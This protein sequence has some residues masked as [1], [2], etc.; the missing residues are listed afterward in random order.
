[1][2]FITSYESIAVAGSGSVV[3][4]AQQAPRR[5][6][7]QDVESLPLF[8]CQLCQLRTGYGGS[9]LDDPPDHLRY[10]AVLVITP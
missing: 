4:V 9:V 7:P 1:M 3:A 5:S 10:L 8:G 6:V 2:D